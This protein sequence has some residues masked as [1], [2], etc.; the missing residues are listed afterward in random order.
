VLAG[1]WTF[2][3]RPLWLAAAI[4]PALLLA[5]VGVRVAGQT[6]INPVGSVGQV[7]QLTFGALGSGAAGS[8]ACGNVAA[9]VASQATAS[10]WALKAGQRLGASVRPQLAAQA[11]GLGVG[12]LVGAPA[13][14]LLVRAYGL[15][16]ARLPAPGA[17]P[18]KAVHDALAQGVRVLP[19]AAG[20]ACA[21][22]AV[23]GVALALLGQTR[24]RRLVPVPFA[25]AIGMLVPAYYSAALCAGAVAGW[26]AARRGV[27]ELQL[28]T[29]ASGAIIG[30]A[31]IGVAVA[32]LVVLGRLAAPG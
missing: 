10:L 13:Y 19:P 23:I 22:A 3:V 16:S 24:A 2:D 18:W 6:D 12:V 20:A 21:V 26:L 7:T 28:V 17:L 25:L 9:G 30:E 31:L 8:L 11:L 1:W 32:I 4:P 14:A 5:Q 15:G 29:V 27:K